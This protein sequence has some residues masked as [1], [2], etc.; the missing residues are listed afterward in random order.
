MKKTYTGYINNLAENQI[1]VFGSNVDGWHG[2]GTAKI[3]LEKFGAIYGKGYGLN[4]QS[5]GLVTVDLK[6]RRAPS[7]TKDQIKKEID[8]LYQFAKIKNDKEFLIA[9]TATGT[10][11]N[12]YSSAEMAKMFASFKIPNNVIFEDEFSR[13]VDSYLI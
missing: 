13:L 3:A 10:N 6:E 1:F 9:Y 4:G 12:G 11:L 7:R 8:L 2:A 5:Y